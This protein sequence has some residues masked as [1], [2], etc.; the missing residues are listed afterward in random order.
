LSI[1]ASVSTYAGGLRKRRSEA[2]NCQSAVLFQK[3]RLSGSVHGCVSRIRKG[4]V[5]SIHINSQLRKPKK[6]KC[7]ENQIFDD[8]VPLLMPH[9]L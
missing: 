8:F 3:L 1:F 4:R 5:D 7:H 9:L 2:P 6:N